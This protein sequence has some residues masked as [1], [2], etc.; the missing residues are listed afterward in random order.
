M[1]EQLKNHPKLTCSDD[2]PLPF[3]WIFSASKRNFRNRIQATGLRPEATIWPSILWNDG[4]LGWPNALAFFWLV[5]TTKEIG[6]CFFCWGQ[7]CC[8]W[9]SLFKKNMFFFGGGWLSIFDL[10]RSWKVGQSKATVFL[11]D[12]NHRLVGLMPI[13]SMG[14]AYLRTWM[15]NLYGKLVGKSTSPMDG[16]DI[17]DLDLMGIRGG[18]WCC[19]SAKAGLHRILC[20]F[21]ASQSQELL[22]LYFMPKWNNILLDSS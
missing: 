6:G 16:I 21:V 20:D 12:G 17:Y 3:G 5:Q 22:Q 9:E 10:R 13:V 11:D 2:S 15:V 8:F 19:G 18:A 7:I 4:F 1:F 14:V